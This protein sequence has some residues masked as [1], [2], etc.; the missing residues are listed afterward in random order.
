MLGGSDGGRDSRTDRNIERQTCIH[1]ER[2]RETERQG[3]R[4]KTILFTN[5]A[6]TRTHAHRQQTAMKLRLAVE[7]KLSS[8]ESLEDALRR[9]TS[10]HKQG[11]RGRRGGKGRKRVE[12]DRV[13]G[14]AGRYSI[15]LTLLGMLINLADAIDGA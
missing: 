13:R 2:H 5:Y 8:V 4:D 6:R 15:D 12:G 3:H 11:V 1:R 10:S 7:N 9:N 14:L